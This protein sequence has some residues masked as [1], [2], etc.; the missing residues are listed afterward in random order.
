MEKPPDDFGEIVSPSLRELPGMIADDDMG[1][2]I[3]D[4]LG[5]VRY[6]LAGSYVVEGASRPI[7]SNDEIM[8][9]LTLCEQA[10]E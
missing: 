1:F 2:Y 9:A 5:V 3:V 8:R 6:S 4:K 7:P 10:R